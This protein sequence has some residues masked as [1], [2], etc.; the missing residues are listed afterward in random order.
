MFHRHILGIIASA[1]IAISPA[2]VTASHNNGIVGGIVGGI[3]GGAIVNGINNNNNKRTRTRTVY[4]S[5]TSSATRAANRETQTAL[6]YF[7]YPAGTPDGVLGRRS[8]TAI[9]GYQAFLGTPVTGQLTQFERDVLVGAYTRGVSGSYE[10][11]QL[12]TN[13]PLG[14]KALLIAQRDVLTGGSTPTRTTGYAGLPLEVSKAVDEIADSSDPSAEQLL[15]RSGFIQ[16]AD[17]NG[18]GNNDYI[19]DTSFSGSSFW[20]NSVQCKAI[21]FVSTSQGYVRNDMLAFNPTPASFSCAGSSCVLADPQSTV[22]ASGEAPEVSVPQPSETVLA[23]SN[24]N[25]SGLGTLP[26]LTAPRSRVSL[27]SHCSKVSLLTNANGGYT[28]ASAM[29]DP[30]LVLN[31]QFCLARAFAMDA[32]EQLVAGMQG[33]T[34]AQVDGQCAAYG[35]ALKEYVAALP[36]K[37]RSE[38]VREVGGFVLNSGMD[39]AQLAL[40]A[41]VCLSVGYRMEDMDM[42]LGSAL[43]LVVLGEGPYGE[44]IGHH[45]SQGLGAPERVDLSLEWYNEALASID[46]GAPAVFAPSQSDRVDLLY[47][48]VSELGG[49]DRAPVTSTKSSSATALPTFKLKK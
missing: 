7:G 38:V 47:D 18:D 28:K 25:G 4:R 45:L 20:C 11:Q 26:L 34:Q 8:R 10:T 1:A 37:P 46:A 41:K 30:N 15:Q 16:L 49:G 42:A 13:D 12:I 5:G 24:T 44:L 23:N 19:L 14:S 32:G 6:N 33:V 31:E 2:A 35:P 9:S 39:P 36:I 29:T 27:S 22:L 40:T 17:L 21:V 43:L 48:A 3:I